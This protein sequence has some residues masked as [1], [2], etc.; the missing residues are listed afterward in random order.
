MLYTLV[1][2]C[3]VG[4]TPEQCWPDKADMSFNMTAQDEEK[5]V[6]GSPLGSDAKA[7]AA[8]RRIDLRGRYIIVRNISCH[9]GI[10]R[11]S[12][13]GEGHL[14]NGCRDIGTADGHCPS[15]LIKGNCPN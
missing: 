4:L 2:I 10:D 11:I 6:V 13:K 1:L 15:P 14:P 9:P 5:A 7:A 12:R 8:R 3:S